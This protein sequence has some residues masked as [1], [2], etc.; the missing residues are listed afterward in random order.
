MTNKYEALLALDT[1][2]K[3][4]NAKEAISR[5]EKLFAAES[6]SI[7]EVKHLERREFAYEHNHAKSGYF[8]NINFAAEAV[9]IDKIR[10]KLKLDEEVLLQNFIKL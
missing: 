10:A 8:I 5:I 2:G 3:D 9:A 1:R 6:A 4:D 7:S